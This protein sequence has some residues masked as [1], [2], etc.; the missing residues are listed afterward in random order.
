MN[1]ST[2]N[3][4]IGKLRRLFAKHVLPDQFV[5]DNGT[6]FTSADFKEFMTNNGIKHITSSPY[7]PATNGQA[8]SAVQSVKESLK[9][10][11]MEILKRT[12]AEYSCN[13]GPLH[14]QPEEYHQLNCS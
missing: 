1:T 2:L 13:I 14:I 11:R 5:T 6:C 8:E 3:A 4:T 12:Y 10:H 7:H 9:R